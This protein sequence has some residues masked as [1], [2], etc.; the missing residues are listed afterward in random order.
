[1]DSSGVLHVVFLRR[2]EPDATYQVYYGTVDAD[3]NT[4]EPEMIS[5][6]WV[7]GQFVYLAG[8]PGIFASPSGKVHIVWRASSGTARW[9]YRVLSDGK[10]G[11]EEV[12]VDPSIYAGIVFTLWEDPSGAVYFCDTGYF[13]YYRDSKGWHEPIQVEQ[14]MAPGASSAGGEVTGDDYGNVMIAWAHGSSDEVKYRQQ[15]RFDWSDDFPLTT[16]HDYTGYSN[17]FG[18]ITTDKD[19]LAVVVWADQYPYGHYEIFMRRQ[20]ME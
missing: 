17:E 11:E 9:I 1:M 18:R 14:H 20:I 16:E 7:D 5:S 19:G 3:G 4:S 6:G 10:W 8:R 13:L 15:Y 12:V 2:P